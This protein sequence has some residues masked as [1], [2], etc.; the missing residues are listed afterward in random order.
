M[1]NRLVHETSPYLLQHADNPVEWYPW[2]EEALRAAREQDKPILLSVGYAACHWCHVM[3]HE[4]FEDEETAA[5]MNHHFIN[6]K[7]D[8]EE[9]PELDSIYMNAVVA[10]TG[11][12]GWPMTVAL[13]P[14]G[15]P[16]FG[17]TY[18]P[19]QPRYGMPGFKQ[20]LSS[21]VEAWRRRR[22]DVLQNADQVADHLQRGL[23]LAG[24][25]GL[26]SEG[27]LDRAVQA[28]ARAYDKKRGGFGHAPKFP[29]PMAIEFLLR[30]YA[31]TDDPQLLPM[32]EH[33][34]TTMA[35][36][37]MYDQVGGG[38]ARYS[39]DDHWLVPHFEKMLYDNALLSRA[40]LHAWQVTGR[41]L[42]RRV[43][44]ETLDYLL[45]EMRDP[46]GGFYSSQDA[47]SEGEEGKFYVWSAAEIRQHLGDEADLFM[48]YYDVSNRGNWEGKNILNV[49]REPE[50]VARLAKIPV[51][52][53]ESR[54]AAA[55]QKL[56]QVRARRVWPGRDE[57]V[58]TAWNG[59]LLASLAEAGRLLDRPEYT[60]AAVENAEFLYREVRQANGRLWR[61]WK[62]GAGA[63]HNGY[64]EDYTHL[65]DG[66]L[67]LYQTTF[68]TRWFKWTLELA[69]L[70]VA[71][72]AD[73]GEGGFFDTSDDHEELIVR[74][75]DAQDNATPSGNAMAAYLL[76][77]LSLYTG[78][79][80]YW[81]TA[82]KMTAA[83]YGAMAQYPLAFAHWL[84]AAAFILSE[85][86]E[87][88]IVGDL[89]AADT[90]ALL[91]VA[92]RPYRPFQ[93]VA[94]GRPA[95]GAMIPLLA[96]RTMADG[97]VTAYV[98]RHFACQMPTT[99][100]AVLA[101][102]LK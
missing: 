60:Q 101:E 30:R 67:A 98:C 27:L 51:E 1:P 39:T 81:A 26:L 6:I 100:P 57:K 66:L 52:E 11:Q 65:A 12:G 17:G 40:Y 21:L 62:A 2:G 72:F 59:L 89:E 74:P 50:E 79:G 44:E 5:Y 9:R 31:R 68:D 80:D 83:L 76:L 42:Y 55:C 85:P 58:L 86:R 47:D 19:R 97:R 45:R 92:L 35:R 14:D 99:D 82:E 46:A 37:G 3:A 87:I 73:D 70:M 38:F 4:S 88:A 10:M 95:G 43:V 69:D 32:V 56:Y 78:N 63:R 36:G 15:R 22:Q 64:L 75:K 20:V 13:T 90:Q 91:D 7:V 16:F 61:S 33:T 41:P 8:R 24:Q 49:G 77:R 54:L 29:Q 94:V 48:L 53:L 96:G 23:G 93:V 102:Q 71:H 34:L 28:M 18:F 84:G 25:D